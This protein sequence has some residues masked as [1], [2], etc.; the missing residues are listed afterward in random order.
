MKNRLL[1]LVSAL[2]FVLALSTSFAL[3]ADQEQIHGSQLMTEQERVEYR[4]KISSAKTAEEREQIRKEQ[5]ES[6]KERAKERGFGSALSDKPPAKG[7]G[8]GRGGR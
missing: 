4:E 7:P 3:A 1:I 8:G 6:M 5:L 2:I